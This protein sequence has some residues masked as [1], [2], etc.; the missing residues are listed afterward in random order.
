MIID[1]FPASPIS[2]PRAHAWGAARE[3]HYRGFT[4]PG[5]PRPAPARRTQPPRRPAGSP[6]GWQLSP[7]RL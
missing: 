3:Q 7:G 2:S 6:A 1:M 5:Q 4:G